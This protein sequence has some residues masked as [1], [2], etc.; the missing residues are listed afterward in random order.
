MTRRILVTIAAH[1]WKEKA[2]K[3]RK[4][5]P[6]TTRRRKNVMNANRIVLGFIAR[7]SLC[8]SVGA[9]PA[10]HCRHYYR[11]CRSRRLMLH[12]L[13][14]AVSAV[15]VRSP[16]CLELMAR[17]RCVKPSSPPTIP[18]TEDHQICP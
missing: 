10:C 8:L 15:A 9:L 14:L 2:D 17:F 18:G 7:I 3:L 5:H 12:T 1:C 6:P 11:H 16:T 13:T 4:N